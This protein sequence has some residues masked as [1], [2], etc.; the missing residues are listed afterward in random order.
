M[1]QEEHFSIHE[2]DN[3][4][5][6]DTGNVED[7]LRMKQNNPDRWLLKQSQSDKWD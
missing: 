4:F 7:A 5:S 3:N 2:A 6:S 1:L